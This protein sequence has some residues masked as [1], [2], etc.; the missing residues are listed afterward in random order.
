MLTRLCAAGIAR[1][2]GQT[3]SDVLGARTCSSAVFFEEWRE[4]GCGVCRILAHFLRPLFADDEHLERAK[5]QDDKTSNKVL[6][7][8]AECIVCAS[9]PFMF[10]FRAKQSIGVWR[11][12]MSTQKRKRVTRAGCIY[13]GVFDLCVI[14]F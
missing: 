7:I 1:Q 14:G 2:L 10:E 6:Q 8:F 12:L 4:G 13:I 11:K 5:E 9:R 3:L